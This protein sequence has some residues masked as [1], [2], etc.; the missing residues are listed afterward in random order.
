MFQALIV[1]KVEDIFSVKLNTDGGVP[2]SEKLLEIY[3]V[4]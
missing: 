1:K 4:N 3:G 2:I